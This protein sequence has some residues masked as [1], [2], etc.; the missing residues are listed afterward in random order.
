LIEIVVGN[1]A[2]PMRVPPPAFEKKL[3]PSSA[4]R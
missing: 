1:S 2:S 3:R 4:E